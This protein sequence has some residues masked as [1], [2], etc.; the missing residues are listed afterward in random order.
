MIPDA[1]AP[2]PVSETP[3]ITPDA[4]EPPPKLSWWKR[5]REGLSRSS[6]AIGGG[7]NDI[8][9]K[10]KLDAD[11][12]QELEDVLIRADLGATASLRITEA[13]AKGRY[14]KKRQ[15]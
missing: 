6:Q 2:E 3:P 9:S 14:D 13:V 10:R 15:P 11:T 12:L 8:F 1:S 5:L 7:I 4:P